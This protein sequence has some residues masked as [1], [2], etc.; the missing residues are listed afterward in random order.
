M[1]GGF[2]RGNDNENS[3][4]FPPRPM[5]PQP[6]NPDR[7]F[8]QPMT[9]NHPRH[10]NNNQNRQNGFNFSTPNQVQLQTQ[11]INTSNQ[12]QVNNINSNFESDQYSNDLQNLGVGQ[13]Y[14]YVNNTWDEFSSV[15][16]QEREQ[17]ELQRLIE[18]YNKP[19]DQKIHDN[20]V[21]G[22]A[23]NLKKKIIVNVRIPGQVKNNNKA[24]DLIGGPKE[25]AKIIQE[26]E[27]RRLNLPQTKDQNKDSKNANLDQTLVNGKQDQQQ[28]QNVKNLLKFQLTQDSKVPF[29]TKYGNQM[30]VK[31]IKQVNRKTGEV[32]YK[33]DDISKIDYEFEC[34]ALS[35]FKYGMSGNQT[36]T[37]A[38]QDL[39]EQFKNR[40]FNKINQQNSSAQQQQKITNINTQQQSISSSVDGK[41]DQQ[42]Q[43]EKVI[44]I[45][46][47]NHEV[48]LS[49]IQPKQFT[50]GKN[51]YSQ[52]KD[53]N[54]NLDMFIKQLK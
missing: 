17:Q 38:E 22:K 27:E 45:V 37:Q 48:T 34:E 47:P 16:Q 42:N 4:T 49:F 15:Q 43:Q 12:F 54:I 2:R 3:W 13:N 30:A 26:I 5:H 1:R 28:Q 46:E 51:M 8:H 52:V 18:E 10:L 36:K 25:V 21:E 31:I 9:I 20:G 6:Q 40:L 19:F 50:R 24:L 7:R 32:R 14:T 44:N 53:N 33:I 35:D 39:S 29:E 41:V 23:S 11:Q